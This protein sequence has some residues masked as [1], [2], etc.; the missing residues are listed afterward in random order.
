MSRA[1]VDL[2]SLLVGEDIDLDTRERTGHSGN[3]SRLTP[4]VGSVL[5]SVD[6]PACVVASAVGTA[7]T[8]KI[9]GSQ[10]GTKLL[11]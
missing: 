9:R 1:G 7:A 6:E 8:N 3:G 2:E 11:G 5:I 4:V 10:I